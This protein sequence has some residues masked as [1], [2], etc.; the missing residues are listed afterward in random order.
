[1]VGMTR[2]KKD[3]YL[4]YSGIIHE[5]V[6]SFENKCTKIDIDNITS[7]NIDDLVFDF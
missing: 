7:S 5:Y 4:T 1:M 6:S 2:S 3:L